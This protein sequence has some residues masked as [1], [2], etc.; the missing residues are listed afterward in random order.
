[1]PAWLSLEFWQQ[2]VDKVLIQGIFARN[3]AKDEVVDR[4]HAVWPKLSSS[5]LGARME[6]VARA[7]LPRW[8]DQTFWA[9]EV[10]PILLSGIQKAGQCQREAVDMVLR[11][12]PQL[13]VGMIWDRLRR[14]RKQRT[15][16]LQAVVPGFA[17][18]NGCNPQPAPADGEADSAP[19]RKRTGCAL[20]SK[21][22]QKFWRTE[23]DP[24]LLSGIRKANRCER[25]AVDKVLRKFSELRVGAIWARLRRLQEQR[26]ENGH[27]PA[28]SMDE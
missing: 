4:I 16:D 17:A 22:D 5:W 11:T 6:E 9:A 7:G 23:V 28:V 13:Q 18:A 24:I 20:P 26:K 15:E 3:V 21:M 8:M 19:R 14:L 12:F 1:M 10:D 2:E 27:G 25:E